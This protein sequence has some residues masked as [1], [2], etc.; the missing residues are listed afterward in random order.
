MEVR[1]LQKEEIP[2]ALSLAEEVFM[3]AHPDNPAAGALLNGY[4]A[5]RAPLLEY[6]GAFEDKLIGMLA[7]DPQNWHICLFY[8]DYVHRG[9]GTQLFQR[10]L[11]AAGKA[12]VSKITVNADVLALPVYK[13]LGFE[14]SGEVDES[15][16]VPTQP[17]E[18]LLQK[19]WL[20][21]EID[22]TIDHPCGSFHPH[23]PDLLYPCNCGYAEGIGT[24]DGDFQDVYVYG[25]EEPLETFHGIVIAIIYR[26]NESDSKWVAAASRDYDRQ[27]VINTIGPL[28][29]YSDTRV[30]WLEKN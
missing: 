29:Q 22:I 23:V 13:A 25:P 12:R 30:I 17:M 5:A 9:I 28:E 18:Y 27:D 20:G 15:G 16:G 11:Q 24:L 4:I 6:L 1:T 3:R 7:Y 26:R 19:E 8:T 14:N 10:L 21:K 2:S